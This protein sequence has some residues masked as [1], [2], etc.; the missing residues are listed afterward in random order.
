MQFTFYHIPKT[1]GTS[2]F[3]MTEFWKNHR[4]A[5][6]E[7]NHIK[8][9]DFPP[10]KDE[11][12]YAIIRDPYSRFE[13][14]FYHIIDACNDSF[15]YKDALISDCDW[16]KSTGIYKEIPRFENDPNVFVSALDNKSH[17]LHIIARKIYY[18][19]D[20]FRPQFY[21]L[22]NE[23][24]SGIFPGILI[25]NHEDLKSTVEKIAKMTGNE[26]KWPTG[27]KANV[28]ITTSSIPL[29][30]LSRRIIHNIL[31]KVDFEHFNFK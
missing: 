30:E 2:I 9:K 17:P 11:H 20:I 13:S 25:V 14:A 10:H 4:R 31:Y 27:N 5:H 29:N 6:P 21:W 12:G 28:R 7:I 3:N 24:N 15:Y 23:H 1:G 26:I 18:H 22:S 19:F 8:A 16:L